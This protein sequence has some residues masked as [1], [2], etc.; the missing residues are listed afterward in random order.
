M[1]KICRIGYHEEKAQSTGSMNW[2]PRG[3]ADLGRMA[4]FF[5]ELGSTGDYFKGSVEQAHSFGDLVST[6][7]K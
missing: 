3:F 5:R 7:K 1:S 2:A 6:A 4:I